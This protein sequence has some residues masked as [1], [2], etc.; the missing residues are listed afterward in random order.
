VLVFNNLVC[1]IVLLLS[2]AWTVESVLW[3][4]FR[5]VVIKEMLEGLVRLRVS[6]SCGMYA[7]ETFS[8]VKNYATRDLTG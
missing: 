1:V 8:N 4:S 5:V 6:E 2:M 3:L 7:Q